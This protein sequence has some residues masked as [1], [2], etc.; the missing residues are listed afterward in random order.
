MLSSHLISVFFLSLLLA[1]KSYANPLDSSCHPTPSPQLDQYIIAYGSLMET[2]SKQGTDSSSGAN[3]PIR[4][5]HYQRGWFS[6]GDSIGFSTTYL[7]VVKGTNAHFN[8]TFF[9][10]TTPDSLKNYDKREKYYCRVS[11]PIS[12]IHPLNSNELPCG[13]FWIYELKPKF[14][15]QPS[16]KYPIIESYVDIFLSGCLEIQKKFHLSH[17]AEECIDT[18]THWSPH[19]VNDRIYPRRPFV[20]EPNALAIDRL[21][22]CKIPKIFNQIKL[23]ND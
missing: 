18:T 16:E 15:A 4:V 19:W 1:A 23:E 13:E 20:F 12:Y 9:R 6:R 7:G 10:L 5:S 3:K 14:S 21:L 2:K 11:I 8:G 17:F 22:H